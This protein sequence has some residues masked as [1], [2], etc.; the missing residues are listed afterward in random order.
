MKYIVFEKAG[1]PAEI[2][3]FVAP[4]QHSDVAAELAP[5][6]YVPKSAGFYNPIT[7]HAYGASSSLKISADP[8]DSELIYAMARATIATGPQEPDRARAKPAQRLA[9]IQIAE[10]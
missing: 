8:R 5:K 6:G 10:R 3:L 1:M 2:R 7:G 4:S 9:E